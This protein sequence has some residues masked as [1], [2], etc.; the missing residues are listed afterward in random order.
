MFHESMS[1]KRKSNGDGSHHLFDDG[2]T[3]KWIWAS[4]AATLVL[5]L[6]IPLYIVRAKQEKSCGLEFQVSIA[7]DKS[8]DP[9]LFMFL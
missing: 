1:L 3:Y 6:R 8:F 5:V 7:R 9:I 4:F 2:R